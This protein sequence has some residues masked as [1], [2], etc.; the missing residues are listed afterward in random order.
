MDNYLDPLDDNVV[1]GSSQFGNFYYSTDN[2]FSSLGFYPNVNN[3]LGEWT[4][5]VIADYTQPGTFYVVFENVV[6]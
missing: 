4:T 1:L 6:K 2:G 5:P 3:E